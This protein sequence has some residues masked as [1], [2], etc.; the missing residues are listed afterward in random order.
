[1][2]CLRMARR[3]VRWIATAI[4]CKWIHFYQS[5]SRQYFDLSSI[6]AALREFPESMNF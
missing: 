5:I 4:L 3:G 6:H 2:A 1:V